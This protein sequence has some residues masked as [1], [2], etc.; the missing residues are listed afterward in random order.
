M[1]VYPACCKHNI[2]QMELQTMNS[3][4]FAFD[5]YSQSGFH[6][7]PPDRVLARVILL[8][9]VPPA[10]YL[11]LVRSI[12][13]AAGNILSREQSSMSTDS[14]ELHRKC[15]FSSVCKS[16]TMTLPTYLRKGKQCKCKMQSGD[17]C[18]APRDTHKSQ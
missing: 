12:S 10:A 1:I 18:F 2:I 4:E 7:Q 9:N 15:H 5:Q 3:I 11:N 16:C 17:L 8:P 14:Q 13:V 6:V